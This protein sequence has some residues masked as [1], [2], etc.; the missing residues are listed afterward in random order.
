MGEVTHETTSDVGPL[1]VD[2][3]CRRA[4]SA[5]ICRTPEQRVGAFDSHNPRESC[6]TLGTQWSWKPEDT[7][8]SSSERIR[9]LVR[10]VTGDGNLL[11]SSSA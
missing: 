3:Q 4:L 1:P 11:P 5:G 6:M 9:I 7:L 2:A 8:K 10:C